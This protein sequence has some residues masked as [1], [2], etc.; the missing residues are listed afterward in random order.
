M[1]GRT[2]AGAGMRAI[3]FWVLLSLAAAGCGVPDLCVDDSPS[4]ATIHQCVLK[5]S[6]AAFSS[7]HAAAG[8]Q[9]GLDL[10]TDTDTARLYDALINSPCTNAVAKSNGWK[11][12]VPGDPG[13]S[14][15]LSKLTLPNSKEALGAGT[16]GP[17]GGLGDR[18]P[19]TGQTLDSRS[20]AQITAWIKMG[21]P[22]N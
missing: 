22:N 8:H 11:R 15:L 2:A 6:C 13:A 7:C 21:A 20:I 19:D 14:Y 4:F 16:G 9:G 17:N 3:G 10:Q 18:M 1:S 5:T 12:V